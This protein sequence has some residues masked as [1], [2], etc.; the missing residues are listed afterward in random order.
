[1]ANRWDLFVLFC[2]SYRVV[3]VL[4]HVVYDSGLRS[5][6]FAGLVRHLDVARWIDGAGM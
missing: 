5:G 1:M 3:V 6:I 2:I 4:L